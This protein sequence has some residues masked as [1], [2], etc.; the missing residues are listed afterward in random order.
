MLSTRFVIGTESHTLCYAG[1]VQFRDV[2][3]LIIEMRTGAG[4]TQAQL[5][6]LLDEAQGTVSGWENWGNYADDAEAFA[7]LKR[8]KKPQLRRPTIPDVAR[9][10]D[11]CNKEF[12][13]RIL[14]KGDAVAG[15]LVQLYERLAPVDRDIMLRLARGM[16]LTDQLRESLAAAANHLERL[17]ATLTKTTKR[18]A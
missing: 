9:V 15:E 17:A 11:V 16:A 2:A 3:R 5:A 4:L 18:R 13:L 1:G 8:E 10:A 12:D 6:Q 14:P 7:A